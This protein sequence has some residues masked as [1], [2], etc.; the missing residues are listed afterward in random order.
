MTDANNTRGGGMSPYSRPCGAIAGRFCSG[1]LSEEDCDECMEFVTTCDECFTPGSNSAE[2]NEG[3]NGETLCDVC[4]AR[5]SP[6][7]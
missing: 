3:P 2:W 4:V 1:E 6:H 5:R 7:D